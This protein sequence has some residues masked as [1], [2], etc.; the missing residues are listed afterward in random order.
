[1]KSPLQVQFCL[2]EIATAGK[3]ENPSI[4]NKSFSFVDYLSPCLLP[5]KVYSTFSYILMSFLRWVQFL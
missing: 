2:Q 1:M 4:S 5:G 3:P